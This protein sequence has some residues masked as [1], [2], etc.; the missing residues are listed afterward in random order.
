MMK[1]RALLIAGGLALSLT[2]T[3]CGNDDEAQAAEAISASMMESGDDEFA[4]TQEQADCVGEGMVDKIGVDKLQ[5][6]GILTE[7]LTADDTVSDVT[8]EESD[9]DGAAETIVGCADMQSLMSEQF[10]AGGDLTDEQVDCLNEQ[11]DDEA[12]TKMFSLVFQGKEDEATEDLMGPVMS[13]M[14]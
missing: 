13:C 6:Y 5:E 1:N 11:L 3:A 4:L 2:L 14:M 9:A 12:L 8:F 7:D 10:S